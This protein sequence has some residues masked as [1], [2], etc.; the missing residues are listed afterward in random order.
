MLTVAGDGE[1]GLLGRR[2]GAGKLLQSCTETGEVSVR[3][4][5]TWSRPEKAAEL[6]RATGDRLEEAGVDGGNGG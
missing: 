4:D 6:C 1:E 3:L 2:R 5:A